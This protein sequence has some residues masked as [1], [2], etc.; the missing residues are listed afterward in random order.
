M[1]KNIRK[2]AAALAAALM[3]GLLGA[4]AAAAEDDVAYS[5]PRVTIVSGTIETG[6]S[7]LELRTDPANAPDAGEKGTIYY[8]VTFYERGGSRVPDIAVRA[9]YVLD[10]TADEYQPA[11]NGYRFNGWYL[12]SARKKAA[13]DSVTVNGTLSLYADWIRESDKPYI[14]DTLLSGYDA[15]ERTG[16]TVDLY[17]DGTVSVREVIDDAAD[18]VTLTGI[19]AIEGELHPVRK[20]QKQAFSNCKAKEIV[21]DMSSGSE[22][23]TL[24]SRCFK[25][26][27]NLTAITLKCKDPAIFTVKKD[28]FA[29][30]KK[31]LAVKAEGLSASQFSR[32]RSAIRRS[33]FKGTVRRVA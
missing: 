20:I 30:L 17:N 24:T 19:V 31:N 8:A 1:R 6:E 15:V 4:G 29:G 27:K 26:D 11:R 18:K 32:L 23:I 22:R 2:A 3:L 7:S 12:D 14:V 13:G 28:A 16:V 33:G 21:L 5:T 25:G 9:G 10:L